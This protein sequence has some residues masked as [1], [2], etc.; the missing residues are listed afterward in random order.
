[1]SGG[2]V[3]RMTR[4]CEAMLQAQLSKTNRVLMENEDLIFWQAPLNFL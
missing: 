3:Y 2:V 4:D 1:M